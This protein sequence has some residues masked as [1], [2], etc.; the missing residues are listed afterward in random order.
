MAKNDGARPPG[1]GADPEGPRWAGDQLGLPETGPGSMAPW[2]RRIIALFID[3]GIAVLISVTWFEGYELATLG[4]FAAGE[5]ILI[6]LLGVTV[7]KRLMRIQVVR[8]RNIPGPLWA[9]VRTLLLMLILP[10]III[11]SDGRG[12]HD[13]AAGTV[14]LRM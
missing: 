14:Q 2:S 13:R 1:A 5:I 8:G 12:V 7:G 11:G 4:I 3:W 10:P 6:G 9:A